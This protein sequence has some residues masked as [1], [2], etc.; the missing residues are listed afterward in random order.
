MVLK[1]ELKYENNNLPPLTRLKPKRPLRLSLNGRWISRLIVCLILLVLVLVAQ[2]NGF[3][4]AE[5]VHRVVSYTINTD[6]DINPWL[7]KY[8]GANF[9]DNL[10]PVTTDEKNLGLTLFDGRVGV[11]GPGGGDSAGLTNP[12]DLSTLQPYPS[13]IYPVAA[14]K[15]VNRFDLQGKS[16]DQG[17]LSGGITIETNLEQKVLAGY[18][19][20]VATVTGDEQ[21]GYS[22]QI[23]H[24][25]GIISITS[26]CS[27]AQ[28]KPGNQ[29]SLGQ[30]IGRLLSAN[31]TPKRIYYEIRVQGKPVDPLIF[32]QTGQTSNT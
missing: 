20:R 27:V 28:V 17:Y 26:G 5:Q 11:L 3:P 1:S 15:V 31:N 23:D 13:F 12:P 21:Y 6:Y 30:E 7:E 14:G 8:R 22:V 18:S 16:P 19:G 9:W 25:Q 2:Q 4:G 32:I 29:V 24:G 10:K